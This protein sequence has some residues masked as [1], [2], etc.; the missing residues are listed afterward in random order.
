MFIIF[1]INGRNR[2]VVP[3]DAIFHQSAPAIW[4]AN[5]LQEHEDVLGNAGTRS[6]FVVYDAEKGKDIFCTMRGYLE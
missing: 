3:V 1:E 5:H 2:V 6:I 4:R